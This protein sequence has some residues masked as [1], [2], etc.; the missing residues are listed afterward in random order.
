MSVTD[1]QAYRDN[2]KP[3]E[4]AEMICLSCL[5]RFVSV[6]P[7]SVLLKD[8]ECPKCSK[9]GFIIKTG[10]NIIEGSEE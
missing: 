2:K 9:K 6:F 3:H 8:L 4:V 5:K 10:Q 7:V 1:M